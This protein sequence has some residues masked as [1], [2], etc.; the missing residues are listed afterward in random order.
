MLASVLGLSRT[1]HFLASHLWTPDPFFRKGKES[2]RALYDIAKSCITKRLSSES[3]RR[4]IFAR[5]IEGKV[6]NKVGSEGDDRGVR[7]TES[8]VQELTSEAVTLL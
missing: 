2:S 7:F 1:V 6:A 3:S 5:V 4:D 8:E